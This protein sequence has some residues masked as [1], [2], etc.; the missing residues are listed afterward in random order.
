MKL[1]IF[2]PS[3]LLLSS[4]FV[5]VVLN[6][7]PKNVSTNISFLDVFV[8]NG[9][10]F[11]RR[12]FSLYDLWQK[13]KYGQWGASIGD[14]QGS[15]TVDIPPH[16]VRVFRAVPVSFWWRALI[17][18]LVL[19]PLSVAAAVCL[20]MLRRSR[21]ARGWLLRRIGYRLIPEGGSRDD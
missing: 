9:H 20:R 12:T 10:D 5:F 7:S 21:R 13:D 19:L 2:F 11:G 14:V 18:A 8:D 4:K 16:G 1:L 6:T 3:V 17:V 15:I